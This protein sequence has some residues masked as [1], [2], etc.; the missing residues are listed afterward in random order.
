MIAGIAFLLLVLS[1]MVVA[2]EGPRYKLVKREETVNGSVKETR[3]H[4]YKEKDE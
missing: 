4:I 1:L 3:W 2:Y